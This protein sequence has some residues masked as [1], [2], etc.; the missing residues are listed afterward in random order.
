MLNDFVKMHGLGNDFIIFQGPLKLTSTRIAELCN[1]HTGIGADGVL[2]VSKLEG[3]QI[4]MT[5][6]NADG[7]K[8]EMCGNGLRCAVHFAVNNGL[9]SSVKFIVQTPM[10]PL[11]AIWDG[12]DGQGIEVQ[13]G[14]VKASDTSVDLHGYNFYIVSV[15][16]PHAVTF[17]NDVGLAPVATVGPKVE[18]DSLFLDKTNVEFVEAVDGKHLKVRIWERGIGETLACGTGM[19]AAAIVSANLKKISLPVEVIVPGG[20]AKIWIDDQ[21]YARMIGPAEVVF[22]SQV[23]V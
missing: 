4:E 9:V 23:E 17:V 3:D 19:V 21:Q 7:S 2:V 1:R 6:W 8:A 11:E 18:L 5:Y 16:N 13:V 20:T 10:G 22:I 12:K 14:R 15:G